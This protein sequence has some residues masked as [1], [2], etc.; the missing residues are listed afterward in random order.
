MW[1]SVQ[2]FENEKD[3][4]WNCQKT[5]WHKGITM[6]ATDGVLD[7]AR[8]K[9]QRVE[10]ILTGGVRSQCFVTTQDQWNHHRSVGIGVLTDEVLAMR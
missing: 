10:L 6:G 1:E 5:N 9:V 7:V 3:T 2:I 8:R 4:F